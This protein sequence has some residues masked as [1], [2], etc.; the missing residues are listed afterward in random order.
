MAEN[1]EEMAELDQLLYVATT[2]AADYLILSAGVEEPGKAAG[3]WMELVDRRFDLIRGERRGERGERN[4]VGAE[5]KVTT[6]EPAIQ[7]KPIDLRQRRDLMKIVDKARQMA[8]D[9]EGQRPRY[10]E[11]APSDATARRQYSFSR[12]TGRLHAPT[13][14]ADFS[15]LD[16]DA[17]TAPSPDARGLGTLV[18]AVLAE[19]DFARPDDV[20]ELVRRHAEEQ[21]LESQSGLDEAADMVRRFLVS[22]RAAEIARAGEVHRELEFLLAWPP[23]G[24]EPEGR[25]LPGIHRLPVLRCGRPVAIGRL[26]DESRDGRYDGQSGWA[27]RDADVGLCVGGRADSETP[28][29]RVGVV[30]P[31]A[32]AG[33]WL[34]LG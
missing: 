22:L 24:H 5:V 12:L 11:P 16:A 9:G 15:P 26:Q 29:G 31:S 3:P 13:V 8:G 32:G 17:S 4:R 1:E 14:A 19:I 10:V 18:H 7:S 2:R 25:Y 34:R 6:S 27:V 30:F 33:I 20:M 23:D 21:L 28:A